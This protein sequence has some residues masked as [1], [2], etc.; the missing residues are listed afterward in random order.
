MKSYQESRRLVVPVLLSLLSLGTVL[1][2]PPADA[3]IYDRSGELIIDRDAEPGARLSYLDLSGANLASASLQGSSF[4]ESNLGRARLM[5]ADLSGADLYRAGFRYADLSGANLS[6]ADFYFAKLEDATL[7]NADFSGAA[8]VR[9]N[10][11]DAT[12]HGFTAAQLY[13]TASYQNGDLSRIGLSHNDL[14]GWNF[15][16]KNLSDAEFYWSTVAHADFS[17]AVVTGARFS[18][19]D[20]TAAQLYSTASYQTGDLSGI[21][22]GD[23]DVSR[24][25]FAGK[26]LTG[27]GFS[28]DLT[29]ADFNGA[30]VTGAGFGDTTD[31][32]LTTAQLYSTASYQSGDLSG[33]GLRNN[34]LSGWNF[35][36]KNLTDAYFFF[37]T[38]TGADF[39]GANLTDAHFEFM[40]F[41]TNADFSGAVITGAYFYGSNLTAE[42][43]YSTASYQSGD[44]S[45]IS[46]PDL[47]S[48]SEWDFSGKN[49]TTADIHFDSDAF[50]NFNLC[51]LRGANMTPLWLFSEALSEGAILPDGRIEGLAL[52]AGERLVVRDYDPPVVIWML[53]PPDS[54][55]IT[56]E[57][58]M[59]LHPESALQMVFEDEDW[60]STISFE[61]NTDV[62]LGGTLELLFAE[63]VDPEELIGTTFR[64]FDWDGAVVTGRF[65]QIVTESEAVWDTS[66]LYTTG[67]VKLV[68]E[69]SSVVLLLIAM[70]ACVL[71]RRVRACTHQD[72]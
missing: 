38:L 37:T 42:Q 2:G 44:L 58:A 10:F 51:D 62:A 34:D 67:N 45:G 70:T 56:V 53:D 33:I 52:D 28:G 8:V 39:S 27:A 43:L 22:L 48:D 55:P 12:D 64:L 69:P 61:P 46:L 11:R 9:A 29:D 72:D 36:G 15:A 54:I 35:A 7:T 26:N 57:S 20:F 68:P 23:I 41:L 65:D 66:R 6:G 21:G 14:S 1:S 3:A 5:N 31:N 50:T 59:R 40:F 24:W 18:N 19:T 32:G 16:G 30:I 71:G 60:G 13:S 63:G 25:D 49:L 47:D 17:E 4:R